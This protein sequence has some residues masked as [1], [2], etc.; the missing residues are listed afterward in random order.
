[1]EPARGNP[2]SDHQGV[3][4][5]SGTAESTPVTF[6]VPASVLVAGT[7][8]IAVEVHQD[9]ATSSD[10]SFDLSLTGP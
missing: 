4:H 9:D 5:V 1:V 7:N 2:G 3:G 10:V 6:A 8:V